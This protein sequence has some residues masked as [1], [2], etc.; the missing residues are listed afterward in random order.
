MHKPLITLALF[1][2]VAHVQA[3]DCEA[4]VGSCLMF[5][6]YKE[7]G[8]VDCIHGSCFCHTG[9][10]SDGSDDKVCVK[11]KDLPSML[12]ARGKVTQTG[13]TSLLAVATIAGMAGAMGALVL[14]AVRARRN[15][16]ITSE[17]ILG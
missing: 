17:P 5:D 6:C 11:Y 12:S 8:K 10:C 4:R 7:H 1:A 3:G 15:R 16:D 9:H 2:L 14:T 13:Q